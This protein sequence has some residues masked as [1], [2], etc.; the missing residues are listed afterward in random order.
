[1]NRRE[2]NV[3]EMNSIRHQH[4]LLMGQACGFMASMEIDQLLARRTDLST[5]LVHLTRS[6]ET[7]SA[8]DRLKGILNEQ[9]I[10]ARSAFGMATAELQKR[11]LP[12]DHQRAVCFTETPLQNV[13]LLTEK[14]AGRDCQFEPYGI[15]IARKQARKS[16]ANPVWYLDITPG[17]DWLTNPVNALV[18]EAIE[19]GDFHN[20]PIAKLTPFLEQM[21]SRPNGNDPWDRGYKKEF[22]WEREWRHVG[23]FSL[24]SRYI[25]L[26]PSAEIPEIKAVIDGLLPIYEPDKVSYI[27]PRWSLEMIIGRLAGLGSDDLG[28]F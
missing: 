22:W 26:C 28:A 5:F 9:K 12:E 21:G 14:I 7:A 17:H 20:Q 4:L 11:Q 3:R 2:S 23:D 19:K 1:M 24:P 16:G 15:A 10:F 25:V 6:D 18:N 27:D 8:K 13:N